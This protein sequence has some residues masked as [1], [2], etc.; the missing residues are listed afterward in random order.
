[1]K[2]V[3]SFRASHEPGNEATILNGY[4]RDLYFR[5]R[6][7]QC[8]VSGYAVKRSQ[9]LKLARVFFSPVAHL[10]MQGCPYPE[11]RMTGQRN[12][13]LRKTLLF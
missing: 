7:M 5:I 3:A 8:S 13:N 6:T 1:M 12:Q 11:Q 2:N 4:P 10:A 9:R